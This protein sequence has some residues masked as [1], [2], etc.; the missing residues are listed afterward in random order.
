MITIVVNFFAFACDAK[1]FAC[2]VFLFLLLASDFRRTKGSFFECLIYY[3]C[4][5]VW[6]LFLDALEKNY[7]ANVQLTWSFVCKRMTCHLL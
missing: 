4:R 1:S 7:M 3:Y 2:V 6:P 5:H